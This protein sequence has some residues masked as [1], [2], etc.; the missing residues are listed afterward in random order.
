MYMVM[1]MIQLGGG[2]LMIKEKK[3]ILLNIF[4]K[5]AKEV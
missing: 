5:Q 4:L 3:E 1:V 2:E